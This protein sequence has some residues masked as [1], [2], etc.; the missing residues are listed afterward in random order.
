M[1]TAPILIKHRDSLISGVVS[2]MLMA[3]ILAALII[4]GILFTAN[5]DERIES[6]ARK[7]IA[8]K[9]DLHG[10]DIQIHSQDG[11]VILTGTVFAQPNVSSWAA[12]TVAALPGVKRVDNRLA[13]ERR[14]PG[15]ELAKPVFSG[16]KPTILIK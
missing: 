16:S 3:G 1:K 7:S 12:D 9:N 13:V 4:S 8:L 6:A 2:L 11:V 15:T 5:R 14:G 10:A